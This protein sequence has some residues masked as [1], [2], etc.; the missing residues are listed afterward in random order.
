MTSII[1]I[2]YH[3]I[4][5]VNNGENITISWKEDEAKIVCVS[6]KESVDL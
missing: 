4:L 6:D 1:D 3:N 2:T 5:F